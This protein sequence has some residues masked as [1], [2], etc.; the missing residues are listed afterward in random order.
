MNGYAAIP[1]TII[2][3]FKKRNIYLEVLYQNLLKLATQKVTGMLMKQEG[4]DI[5]LSLNLEFKLQ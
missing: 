5:I 4:K 3:G 2:G 1:G